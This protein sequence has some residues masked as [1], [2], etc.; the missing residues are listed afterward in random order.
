MRGHLEKRYDS[1]WTIIIEAGRDPATG[2]RKRIVRSFKGNK[3]DAEKEMV[4]LIN[5]L[6]KG[7]Y[8]EPSNMSLAEWLYQW[9]DTRK[10]SL[11]PKTRRRY[12][13]CIKRIVQKLGQV[14]IDKL[15]PYHIQQFYTELSDPPGDEEPLAPATVH[16][17]HAVL[18]R[19][20]KDA[21]K[22]QIIQSNPASGLE[23]PKLPKTRV[24]P[25][26][27]KE[28]NA[29]LEDAQ[30]TQYYIPILLAVTCG[31]RR[32][33]IFGL[34]W[35][36]VDL[37]RGILIVNQVLGYTPEDG[38]YFK[39]PKTEE[40]RATITLPKLT[41]EALKQYRIEQNKR[42][43]RKG[44]QWADLDLI[45]DRGDGL[46]HHPD[47]ITSWFPEWMASRGITGETFHGLRHAH[48]S[49]LIDLGLH[50]KMIQERMRHKDI[51]TTM[52][53]YGHLMP[54]RDQQAAGKI[55]E[56]IEG[57]KQRK[58]AGK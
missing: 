23:L 5:E 2:K 17:H 19:A 57:K 25:L 27:Q 51:S 35:Q 40:S 3:R 44:D 52:M 11:S 26:T 10:R 20:L 15:R 54:G 50:P 12:N 22:L 28:I 47:S 43:L 37:D 4:R 38:L 34:R 29:L 24:K 18:H 56:A 21:V 14:Q 32:G 53:I 46:P 42:R 13:D 48:A 8:V 16:Y 45:C 36:D 7:I 9:L 33:E 41:V 39:E 31:L 55:Q 6:E 49:W 30:K 58:K 1:S